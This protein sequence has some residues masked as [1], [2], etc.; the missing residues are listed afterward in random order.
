MMASF[1]MCMIRIILASRSVPSPFSPKCLQHV[2][3]FALFTV[4]HLKEK[5]KYSWLKGA[6]NT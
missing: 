4:Q 6:D 5:K 2:N 1:K 3:D